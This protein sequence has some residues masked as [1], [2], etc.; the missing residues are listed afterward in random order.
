MRYLKNVRREASRHFRNKKWEY[1]RDKIKELAMNSKNKNDGDLYRGINEIMRGYQP[2]SNFKKDGNGDLL[3]QSCNILN[4]RKLYF[5][6]LM[7]VHSVSDG[8]QI[9]V[10]TAETL[11]P[12]HSRLEVEIAIAELKKYKSPGSDQILAK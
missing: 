10:H 6:Q 7:I 1:L 3:A 11:V 8:R 12:G 9:E 2:R 4:R 5:P